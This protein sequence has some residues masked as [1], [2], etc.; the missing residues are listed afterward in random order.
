MGLIYLFYIYLW[1][2]SCVYFFIS[3]FPYLFLSVFISVFLCA[4]KGKTIPLGLDR[5]WG[6]QKVEAPKF[7]D[8]W[9]MK[10]VR[11]SALRTG[12][13]YPQEIF[14]VLISV[15]GWISPRVI[16]R[17]EGLFQWKIAVT[18]SGI[19]PATLRLVAQCFNQ[20]RHQQRALSLYWKT[21]NN[22]Y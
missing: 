11:L 21:F 3:L 20:L 15:R 5:P 2:L 14:L 9:H 16:V 4:E 10:V 8:S 17:Y 7:Q 18:P 13:L 19:E 1:R 6:F 12:R 22:S